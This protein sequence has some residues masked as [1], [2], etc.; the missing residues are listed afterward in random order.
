MDPAPLGG[1]VRS[2]RGDGGAAAQRGGLLR[3]HQVHEDGHACGE[4]V[5]K[6]RGLVD[7]AQEHRRESGG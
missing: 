1:G 7:A 2:V 6:N 5:G 4:R 3:P